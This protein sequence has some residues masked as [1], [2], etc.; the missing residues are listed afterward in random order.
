MLVLLGIFFVHEKTY[1]IAYRTTICNNNGNIYCN[2]ITE[3]VAM[4]IMIVMINA[5]TVVTI[6]EERN[7]VVII[8]SITVITI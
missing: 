7:F 3:R 8:T 1:R 5:I 4:I 6:S 2:D